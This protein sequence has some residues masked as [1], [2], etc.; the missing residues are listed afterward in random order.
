LL[1]TTFAQGKSF[2][3]HPNSLESCQDE[4]NLPLFDKTVLVGVPHESGFIS[5]TR[6]EPSSEIAGRQ[7][8]IINEGLALNTYYSGV[9]ERLNIALTY[10]VNRETSIHFYTYESGQTRLFLTVDTTPTLTQYDNNKIPFNL[11]TS[12]PVERVVITNAQLIFVKVQTTDPNFRMKLTVNVASR[13]EN[14]HTFPCPLMNAQTCL[15]FG[16]YRIPLYTLKENTGIYNV[17]PSQD[18]VK[19]AELIRQSLINTS[20][21][22]PLLPVT[23]PERI[24]ITVIYEGTQGGYIPLSW[25]VNVANN[26]TVPNDKLYTQFIH[27][28]KLPYVDVN[29][30][31][32]EF[33]SAREE[34]NAVTIPL[35]CGD[36]QNRQQDA[37]ITDITLQYE[38][39][40]DG[41]E[42]V[43]LTLRVF[44]GSYFSSPL[45]FVRNG[46]SVES[47][48]YT[49]RSSITDTIN[50]GSVTY[51]SLYLQIS[52][53]RTG[54]FKMKATYLTDNMCP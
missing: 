18:F 42:P 32:R 21:P 36:L 53:S 1:W 22:I 39:V 52:D 11:L 2:I 51:F 38:V 43:T 41:D 44:D 3:P 23:N 31:K 4:Y 12:C 10:Q 48:T 5:F 8:P 7:S 34:W 50:I 19:I 47:V 27:Q 17:T 46:Q 14:T 26:A 16:K 33:S 13:N 54:K 35:T 30:V 6:V 20:L 29:G 49:N 9:G 37:I 28:A 45:T 15:F 25:G 40:I 24:T